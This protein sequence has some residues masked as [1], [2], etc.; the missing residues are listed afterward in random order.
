MEEIKSRHDWMEEAFERGYQLG[1]AHGSKGSGL[2]WVIADKAKPDNDTDVVIAIKPPK[3]KQRRKI[4]KHPEEYRPYVIT[5]GHFFDEDSANEYFG[6]DGFR[7]PD[8]VVVGERDLWTWDDVLA[9]AY[10]N[11]PEIKSIEKGE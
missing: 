11:A 4:A 1:L 3:R 2:T 9:W 6:R 5:A 7:L 8:L 10:L